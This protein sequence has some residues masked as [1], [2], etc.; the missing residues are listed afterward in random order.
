MTGCRTYNRANRLL[1]QDYLGFVYMFLL[2]K[3]HPNSLTVLDL[4]MMGRRKAH[5][6]LQSSANIPIEVTP[7]S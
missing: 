2:K 5:H 3:L 7:G 6:L 4:L 1:E